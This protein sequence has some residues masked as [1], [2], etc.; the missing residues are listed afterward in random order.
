M[1]MTLLDLGDV[2]RSIGRGVIF[3]APGNDALSVDGWTPGTGELALAHLGDTEGDIVFTPHSE[4]TGLTLPEVTGP[5][6]H[7]A[8]FT[9]EA[10]TLSFPLFLAD[11]SLL[12]VITPT[13]SRSGGQS[14]R[15]RA[16]EYTIA[17]FP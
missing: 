14:F 4:T 9:G 10:P 13:S 8:I 7:T 11:P 15:R 6:K 12:D 3:Y 2:L 1:D 5:A 16:K 17:I